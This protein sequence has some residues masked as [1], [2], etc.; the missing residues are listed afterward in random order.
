MC[1]EVLR[2]KQEENIPGNVLLIES[3]EAEKLQLHSSEVT[4]K[5]EESK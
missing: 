5:I 2:V 4:L 3:Q 1:R